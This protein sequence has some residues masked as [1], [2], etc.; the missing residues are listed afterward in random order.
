MRASVLASAE[1]QSVPLCLRAEKGKVARW[2]RSGKCGI[3]ERFTLHNHGPME[4]LVPWMC[5]SSGLGLFNKETE[6]TRKGKEAKLHIS[7]VYLA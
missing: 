5:S 2:S 1:E 6:A 7:T 4:L 3:R